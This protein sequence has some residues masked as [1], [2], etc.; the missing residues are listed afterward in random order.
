MLKI[1]V[2]YT[3]KRR[4]ASASMNEEAVQAAQDPRAKERFIE[5]NERF[6]L[7]C[8][9]RTNHRAVTESDDEWSVGLLAFAEA[10][11]H[12]HPDKGSF[13]S[14]AYMVISRRMNDHFRRSQR[15]REE[16]KVSPHVFTADV[17]DEDIGMAYAVH[18]ATQPAGEGATLQEELK[19]AGTLLKGFDI[20]FFDLTSVSPQT[21]KTRSACARAAACVLREPPLR[22]A[23]RRKHTLPMRAL[24]EKTGISAKLLDRHR[25]YII[26]V[27]V[28]MEGDYPLLQEYLHIVREEMRI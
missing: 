6:I 9:Q 4:R 13:S 23:L 11:D 26:A 28:L 24:Q 16:L 20:S 14:Y 12:Y 3:P 19:D 22:D 18:A 15:A 5:A 7:S 1:G 2:I 8:I 10:I 17:E 27:I 25:K 21:A